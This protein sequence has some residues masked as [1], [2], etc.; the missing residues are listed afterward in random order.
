M[1][2]NITKQGWLCK[3]LSAVSEVASPSTTNSQTFGGGLNDGGLGQ[4]SKILAMD[5]D[6][7][8]EFWQWIG[9]IVLNFGGGLGPMTNLLSAP[10]PPKSE[11]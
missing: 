4:L 2:S 11:F 10:P 5:W 6:K 7:Y 8:P 9:T 1:F 3:Q